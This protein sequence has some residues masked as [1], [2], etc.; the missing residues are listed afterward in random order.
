MSR[1]GFEVDLVFIKRLIKTLRNL[2]NQYQIHL[3]KQICEL[4]RLFVG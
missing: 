3:L 4:K 2:I 1:F